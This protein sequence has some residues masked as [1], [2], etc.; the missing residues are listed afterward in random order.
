MFLI[1]ARAAEVAQQEGDPAAAL[2]QLQEDVMA[3]D[4]LSIQ[5]STRTKE[6]TYH[7]PLLFPSVQERRRCWLESS[8]MISSRT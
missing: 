7:P 4:M 1:G 2:G 6:T 3:R 5:S 8:A